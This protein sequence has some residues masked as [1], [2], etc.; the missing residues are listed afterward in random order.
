MILHMSA[1]P[2]ND[3][4]LEERSALLGYLFHFAG[5]EDNL[6][7]AAKRLTI[8]IHTR[9][10]NEEIVDRLASQSP[11]RILRLLKDMEHADVT[12]PGVPG[13]LLR[14]LSPRSAL[15]ARRSLQWDDHSAA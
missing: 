3:S 12:L 8:A 13:F 14:K 1:K 15:S 9:K 10:V 7:F 5:G 6:A 11:G 4:S 2:T